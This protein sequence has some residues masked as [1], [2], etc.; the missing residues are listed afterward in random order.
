MFDLGGKSYIYL[1]YWIYYCLNITTEFKN[2]PWA[3]LIR[4]VNP[5]RPME[6][7]LKNRNFPKEKNLCNWPWKLCMAFD[8]TKEFNNIDI[9]KE[10]SLIKVFDSNKKWK[11]IKTPRIWIK[12]WK[13]HNLRFL[14]DI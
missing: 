10:N 3:I 4:G 8:I 9:T 13:E 6:K 7:I 5:L 1:I 2:T 12:Q 11:I 14:M